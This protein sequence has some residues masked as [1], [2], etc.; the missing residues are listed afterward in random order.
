VTRVVT[1]IRNIRGEMNI[2]PSRVLDVSVQ[3]ET[4]ATQETITAQRDLILHLAKLTS[5]SVE[6]TGKRP[7]AAATA[8]ISGA[9]I[10]VDLSGVIDFD[11]E[12]GRLEKEMAKVTQ[13]LTAVNKKLQNDQFTGKAPA[14]VVQ[15]VRDKYDLL[16]EKMEK[17]QSNLDRIRE[18]R[19]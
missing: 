13:E 5:L 17:L 16:A 2:P 11:K 18:A 19:G 15:K 12:I 8:V 6:Q 4:D 9:T 7:G 3:T 14:P 1:G 10:Y